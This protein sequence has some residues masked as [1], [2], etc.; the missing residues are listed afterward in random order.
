MR[1]QLL[2][3][4]PP[5]WTIRSKQ[6]TCQQQHDKGMK[7]PSRFGW[8]VL[9]IVTLLLLIPATAISKGGNGKGGGGGTDTPPELVDYGDVFGD[10]MHI[11]RDPLTGQP[12][13]AQRWVEMPEGLPGFGW[14]YCAI[15]VKL[16]GAEIPFKPYSCDL[17]PV[18]PEDV[19]EVDYFGRL[20]ASRVQERNQRMHFNETITNIKQAVRL[21][22]DP[23]GRLDLAFIALDDPDPDNPLCTPTSDA[24]ECDW[25]TVDSPME[26]MAL[27]QRMM[28]YGHIATDPAEEDLWWHGDPKLATPAHPALDADDYA[29]FAAAGLY[30]MLPSNYGSCFDEDTFDIDCADTEELT[31]EDFNT[32]AELLGAAGGKH[33][34][35]TVHLV[36]YLNRFLRITQETVFAKA[37]EK[38]LPA[39]YRDCWLSDAIPEDPLELAEGAV[40]EEDL[41]PYLDLEDCLV[42]DVD[43]SIPNYNTYTNVQERFMNFGQS[44][45]VRNGDGGIWNTR[46]A[47]LA[48]EATLYPSGIVI[49][50]ASTTPRIQG[51]GDPSVESTPGASSDIWKIINTDLLDWI[52]LANNYTPA[53][54][55]IHNFVDAASDA[56]RAI[57]FFHEYAVPENLYCTYI[58]DVY[59]PPPPP[60]PEAFTNE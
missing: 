14:G 42:D 38:T 31:F 56:L 16:D 54:G 8:I 21:R 27:Y 13:F 30:N 22:L 9:M 53:V 43:G 24:K 55:N 15:G 40:Y 6:P 39:K 33:N 37:T 32:S 23:T 10:L 59:C 26:N 35:F 45:Y 44:A 58:P 3:G 41:T 52:V 12:I 7:T 20:N 29:K 18:D 48:L 34:F 60:S 1:T 11:L 46:S 17:D 57:E 5:C 2:V 19:V 28:K 4:R 51:N 47:P 50:P 49:S 36:Q 25:T